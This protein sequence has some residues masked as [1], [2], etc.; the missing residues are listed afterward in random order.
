MKKSRCFFLVGILIINLIAIFCLSLFNYYF[1]YIEEEKAFESKFRESA[2]NEIELYVDNIDIQLKTIM[3]IPSL[4]FS[5]TSDN[6]ALLYPKEKPIIGNTDRI[7]DLIDVMSKIQ[8]AYPYLYSMDIY[9][10][11]S[12]TVVTNFVHVHNNIENENL[13]KLLPWFGKISE[14]ISGFFFIPQGINS[15]PGSYET[16]TYVQTINDSKSHSNDIYVALHI[17]PLLVRFPQRDYMLSAWI[18]D[19]FGNVIYEDSEFSWQKDFINNNFAGAISPY[20]DIFQTHY[21]NNEDGKFITWNSNSSSS[22]LNYYGFIGYRMLYPGYSEDTSRLV[23]NLTFQIILNMICLSFLTIL[24]YKLYKH[25]IVESFK[26]VGITNRIS[27]GKALDTV[28]NA[29]EVLDDKTRSYT[30][31]D[32]LRLLLTNHADK[33]T[34]D[35]AYHE[36]S[37]KYIQSIIVEQNKGKRKFKN[38]ELR[39]LSDSI[40]CFFTVFSYPSRIVF[41]SVSDSAAIDLSIIDRIKEFSETLPIDVGP[42]VELQP[43]GFQNSFSSAMDVYN[44]RWLLGNQEILFYE[45]IQIDNRKSFGDHAGLLFQLERFIYLCDTS[46]TFL[47]LDILFDDLINGNFTVQYCKATLMDLVVA[48]YNILYKNKIDMWDLLGYDIRAYATRIITIVE[49]RVWI[50]NILSVVIDTLISIKEKRNSSIAIQIDKIVEENI[51]HDISLG[52]LADRLGLREDSL[53]RS[54]KSI[55]GQNYME[56]ITE[57]KME[58][59]LQLLDS[60]MSIAQIASFLGYRSPQYFIKIFKNTYGITPHK[61]RKQEDRKEDYT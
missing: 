55:M 7:R 33:E 16:I 45:N 13:M 23:L 25:Y 20:G 5:E 46:N 41:V 24:N 11:G 8:R 15:Y 2:S 17:N 10:K 52:L 12:N 58:K 1:F 39:A 61:F 60:G 34:Y 57:K 30:E 36:I 19:S 27:L 29:Y 26:K 22:S 49:Y 54:F 35:N 43:N 44:Y 9:Y 51:D 47:K 37:G 28:S 48:I 50:R 4:Y 40:G 42:V 18:L 31:Q 53:S 21:I 3:S 56:Y 6:Q 14:D 59:S 32:T 38:E